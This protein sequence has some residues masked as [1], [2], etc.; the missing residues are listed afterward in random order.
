M[1]NAQISIM[2]VDNGSKKIKCSPKSDTINEKRQ[3]QI[4]IS[5]TKEKRQQQISISRTKEKRQQQISISRTKEKKREKKL[6][7]ENFNTQGCSVERERH[8]ER[9]RDRERQRQ[10]ETDRQTDRQ[11]KR[12]KEREIDGPTSINT[13]DNGNENF[14]C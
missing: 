3:Q 13:T 10:R 4:S 9:D 1:N 7:F 5:R 6:E 8:T 12:Y 11:T 2:I 14:P